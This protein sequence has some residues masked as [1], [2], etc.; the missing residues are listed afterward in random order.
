MTSRFSGTSLASTQT[1]APIASSKARD[2]PSRSDGS[3]KSAALVRTSSR[4]S[5]ESQSRNLIWSLCVPRRRASVVVGMARTSGQ[6]QRHRSLR[7]LE[8]VDKQIAIFLWREAAEIKQIAD[9]QPGPAFPGES[10]EGVFGSA[11]RLVCTPFLSNVGSDN[12]PAACATRPESDL[13]AAR[14]PTHPASAHS[15]KPVHFFRCQSRP[16]TVTTVFLPNS[17]GK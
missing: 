14:M 12:A 9:R 16:C 3:T 6:H 2:N 11:F 4:A 13:A 7:L 1:P 10:R 8:C 15:R 5:P 17:R